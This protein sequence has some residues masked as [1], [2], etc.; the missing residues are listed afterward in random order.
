MQ[1]FDDDG[2]IQLRPTNIDADRELVFHRN[3]YLDKALLLEKPGDV[4]EYGELLFN[5]TNSQE[6][7]G[8]RFI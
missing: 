4:V 1:L 7:V 3:I 5:N 6:L 8:K 2:I